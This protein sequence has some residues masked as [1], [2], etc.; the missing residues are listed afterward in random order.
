MERLH[1]VGAELVEDINT[2]NEELKKVNF[3]N[4]NQKQQ[5]EVIFLLILFLKK[6][7]N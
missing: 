4:N 2:L 6:N 1:S 3:E 5:I 7:R